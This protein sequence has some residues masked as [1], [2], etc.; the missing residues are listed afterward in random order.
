ML[1]ETTGKT[2]RP[3]VVLAGVGTEMVGFTLAGVFLDWLV[4]SLPVFTS[5]LTVGGLAVAMWHLAKWA[6]SRSRP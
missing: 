3:V 6:K 2:T 1:P 4:G 5:L